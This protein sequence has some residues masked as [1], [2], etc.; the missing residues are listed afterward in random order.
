M[1][2]IKSILLKLLP[3][4]VVL[5]VATIVAW[6]ARNPLPP[7]EKLTEVGHSLQDLKPIV[8][9]INA[10]F[11]VSWAKAGIS[12]AGP[13]DDLTILRRLS[14]A[15]H[16][17][18]PSLQEIRQFSADNRPDRLGHWTRR[19]LADRRFADYFAERLARAMV[20]NEGGQFIVFR[21]D[22]FVDWLSEQL[23]KNTPYDELV[24]HCI[25]ETG[26]W[27]GNPATNFVTAAVNEGDVDE[28]KLAGKT[29]RAFLGQRID[30]AQC[31][32]HPFDH[33]KQHEFEGLASFYGQVRPSGLVGIEDVV[34]KDGQ[35]IEY[36]VEDRKTL[37][38]RVVPVAVPFLPEC[39]PEE[40]S[41]RERLAAWVVH[42]SNRRF[43]R[44]IANRV[45]GLLFGRAYLEPVDD[46]PDPR[47][48]TQ[49]VLDLL[50]ADFRE[51]GCDLRRLIQ[52]L[53]ASEPFQKS[54]EYALPES[55]DRSETQE[56]MAIQDAERAWAVFPLIRLRPEQV[57]GA[58]FQSSSVQTVD[59]NSHLLFRTIRL[60]QGGQ[61][62]KEYGDF[63]ESELQDRGGTIPQRLLLMN[64]ELATGPTRSNPVNAVGRI[65]LFASTDEKCIETAFL[66]CLCR[67][68]SPEELKCLQE[69]LHG[70]Q[71]NDR[72]DAVE[73]LV[74]TLYNSTEFS[75]NH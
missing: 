25:A 58:L 73:D 68:P 35:L 49:D 43:E 28:N 30:C 46:L 48:G 4:G 70:K 69:E 15:L 13:A 57:I 64:G 42:P 10:E 23:Q 66:S 53:A 52:V 31:H 54:S 40:G 33:W 22:R 18:V 75:W 17:T 5:S 50:G 36:E 9:R 32:D 47:A 60:L 27:T 11:A 8:G 62:V 20:G 1:T 34:Q 45:W 38:K 24:R 51:H 41:R 63:G 12:P 72:R 61:F 56:R 26:L 74:W 39:L 67:Y 55:P 3:L 16:G 19:L 2:A 37:E 71:R 21:R 29:V 7:A 59:Q 14:L 65:A 44:A 6:A